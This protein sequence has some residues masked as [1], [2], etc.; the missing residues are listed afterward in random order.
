M[1]S[2]LG[3]SMYY[4]FLGALCELCVQKLLTAGPLRTTAEYAEKNQSLL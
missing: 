2:K 4:D 1:Q 3:S